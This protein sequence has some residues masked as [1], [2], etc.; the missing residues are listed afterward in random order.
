MKK[1]LSLFLLACLIQTVNATNYYFSA[2]MGDDNRSAGQAQNPATPW[3]SVA[4]L[5]AIFSSLNP[6]DYVL[7]NRGET[8]YGAI[9]VNKSGSGSSPITIGAYGSGANPVITGF[10]GL[11]N[12][13]SSGNG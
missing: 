6:G 2:S 5:N 9:T 8:F 1:V 3:R 10:T 7:F 12:W 11:G 4:K 13:V